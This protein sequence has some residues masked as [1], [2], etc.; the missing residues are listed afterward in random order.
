MEQ[1]LLNKQILDTIQTGGASNYQNSIII[2][3]HDQSKDYMSSM[4]ETSPNICEI[5]QEPP[6]TDLPNKILN[7][8]KLI[9]FI[10]E[11][12]FGQVFLVK[13]VITDK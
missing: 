9:N 2:A 6:T 3:E 4:L 12:A 7:N 13:H 5:Y 11:G 1:S 10:G 8:Y